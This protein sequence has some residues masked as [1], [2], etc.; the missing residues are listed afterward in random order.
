M[1]GRNP[2]TWTTTAALQSWSG[3]EPNAYPQIITSFDGWSAIKQPARLQSVCNMLFTLRGFCNPSTNY[4]QE[5]AVSQF[6]LSHQLSGHFVHNS[7]PAISP[8]KLFSPLCLNAFCGICMYMTL[9]SYAHL[10]DRRD[11]HLTHA[12]QNR[13]DGQA[14]G[15][16][17]EGSGRSSSAWGPQ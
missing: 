3:I 1:D 10:K 2:V 13:E 12:Q 16:L 17:I 6:L 4:C 14:E 8:T 9:K 15:V 11:M 7:Q 5:C